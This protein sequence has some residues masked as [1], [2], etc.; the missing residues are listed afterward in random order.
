MKMDDALERDV[1]SQNREVSIVG[2]EFSFF[3]PHDDPLW[4]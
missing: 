4:V 1:F 3:V 2:F